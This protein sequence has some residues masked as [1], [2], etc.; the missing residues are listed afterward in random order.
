MFT[1]SIANFFLCAVVLLTQAPQL[2]SAATGAPAQPPGNNDEWTGW[3]GNV[4]NNRWNYKNSKLNSTNVDKLVKNCKL[5]YKVGV[6][7]T[8]VIL[9]YTAYYPTANGSFYALNI[10]T[11]Q[12]DWSLNVTQLIYD[13]KTPS[14]QTLNYSLPISRT[15]PQ[16]DGNTLYFG[17]QAMA[18]LMAVD[19]KTGQHL[20]TV[21]LNSH[22]MAIITL[23]PTVYDGKVFSGTSSHEDGATKLATYKCCSFIG[24]FAAFTFDRTKKA[25]TKVWE[26]KTLP[27]GQGWAGAAVWSSQPSIDPVRKQI[28]IGTGNL[29]IAPDGYTQCLGQ[30]PDCLPDNIWQDSV[31]AL[32]I[33]TGKLNWRQTIT[34]LDVWNQACGSAG[35][36]VSLSPYCV[37][38]VGPDADFGMAPSFVPAALGDGTTG[39]DSVVVGQKSGNIFSFDAVT[40]A[41]A[42]N[43]TVGTDNTGGWLSWGIAVDASKVYFTGINYGMK[44]WTL[45]PSGAT[46]NNSAWG[47]LNLKSG[48]PVWE[49]PVP[50]NLLAYSPPGVVNDVVFVGQAGSSAAKISGSVLALDKTTGN[51]VY[52]LPVEGVQ[53]SGIVASGGF[54]MF[55]TGYT[56]RNPFGT[57]SF[58]VYA[59]PG[60]IADAIAE[61]AAN[62]HKNQSS[63]STSSGTA[64]GASPTKKGSADRMGGGVM[65]SAMYPLAL[66]VAICGWLF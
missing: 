15:S 35:S 62:A 25:F 22:P 43:T 55:G 39:A 12:Y 46:I 14:A 64:A 63:N 34:A 54:L 26:V 17:T 32:D 38:G 6:A 60:A 9:N 59:L 30:S 31:L 42:W 29:L 36:P 49:Q 5:D 11:C 8:P 18:L 45:K 41:K 50:D 1:R 66:L 10:A 56:Y 33:N 65:Y 28:F 48:E 52:R 2:V 4:Y 13:F 47:A 53:N 57:G 3:G 21:Q 40:G 27:E 19:V 37:G 61:I 51:T 23:S 24:N 58:Y 44:S 16:I 7:A 20:G